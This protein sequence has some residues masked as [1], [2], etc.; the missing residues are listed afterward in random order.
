MQAKPRFSKSYV[1]R[2]IS[3]SFVIV[4]G[5]RY[6]WA[7]LLHLFEHLTFTNSGIRNKV[8]DAGVLEPTAEVRVAVFPLAI[9]LV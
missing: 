5:M 7:L 4:M 2:Q 9:T 1:V 6:I 8:D 3:R